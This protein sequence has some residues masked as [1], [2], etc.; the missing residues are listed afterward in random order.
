MTDGTIY[1]VRVISKNED[2]YIDLIDSTNRE[3]TMEYASHLNTPKDIQ[4][5]VE[6]EEYEE[7]TKHGFPLTLKVV[8]TEQPWLIDYIVFE[9]EIVGVE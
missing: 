1:T 4:K 6:E 5:E 8:A 9:K 3:A 2:D 7:L